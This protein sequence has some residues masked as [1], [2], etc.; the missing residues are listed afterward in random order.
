MAK[1]IVATGV[2]G[3]KEAIKNGENG[4]LIECVITKV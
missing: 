4:I 2:D 3:S 1:P